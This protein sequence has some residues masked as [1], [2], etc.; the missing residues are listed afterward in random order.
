LRCDPASC[1]ECSAIGP[2]ALEQTVTDKVAH[3][4][5]HIGEAVQRYELIA[6]DETVLER[7]E[8]RLRLAA[9]TSELFEVE[10]DEAGVPSAAAP[11]RSQARSYQA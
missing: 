2:A 4:D 5:D 8:R 1:S 10:A 9:I 6:D 3:A 7:R 11:R